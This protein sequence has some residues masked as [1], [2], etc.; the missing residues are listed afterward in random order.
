MN[1]EEGREIG[2]ELWQ[3]DESTDG[4]KYMYVPWDVLMKYG[5]EVKFEHYRKVYSA[6]LDEINEETLGKKICKELKEDLPERFLGRRLSISDVIVLI[7]NGERNAYFIDSIGFRELPM[8]HW[9]LRPKPG[10]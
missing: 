5:Y 7:N 10:N 3:I 9:T 6:P 1:N 8:F 4:I 2:F